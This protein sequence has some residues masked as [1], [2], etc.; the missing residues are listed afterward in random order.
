MSITIDVQQIKQ[1]KY[2]KSLGLLIEEELYW[3]YHIN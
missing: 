1:V 3:K 2:T